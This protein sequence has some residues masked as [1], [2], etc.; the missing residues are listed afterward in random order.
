MVSLVHWCVWFFFFHPDAVP[1]FP[2]ELIL[3][4]SLS[5]P[6]V[7]WCCHWCGGDLRIGGWLIVWWLERLLL[8]GGGGTIREQ[9]SL[10]VSKSQTENETITQ[11]QYNIK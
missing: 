1:C 9:L 4:P 8:P 6:G 10:Y 11:Y 3:S 7:W 5:T 2:Q